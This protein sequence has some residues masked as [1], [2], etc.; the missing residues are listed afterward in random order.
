MSV[1]LRRTGVLSR[2]VWVVG[3]GSTAATRLRRIQPLAVVGDVIYIYIMDIVKLAGAYHLCCTVPCFSVCRGMLGRA[4][5]L[6]YT[7]PY[8]SVCRGRLRA[9]S[10][11]RRSQSPV[12]H[13]SGFLC[14]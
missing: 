10:E 4:Y 1:G 11:G 7:A 13:F 9:D 5:H 14:V 6:C 12:L 3:G 8:I 2:P